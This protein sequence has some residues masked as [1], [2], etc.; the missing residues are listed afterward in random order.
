[1]SVDEYILDTLREQLDRYLYP[2]QHNLSIMIQGWDKDIAEVHIPSTQLQEVI[3]EAGAE[4]R[5]APACIC[6]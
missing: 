2:L 6:V 1:M 3:R 5:S 4:R